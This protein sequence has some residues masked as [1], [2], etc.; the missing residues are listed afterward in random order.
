GGALAG[1]V[2]DHLASQ[3]ALAYDR[4]H[5]L[6]Y[7][8]NAGSN[9]L[10][11]FLVHGD[12]LV[13]RQVISSGGSFPVSVTTHGGLVYVLNARD[14]GSIQ[15]YLRVGTN[16]LRIPSWHRSLGLD[17]TAAPEF[18]HTPGQ[19]A[20]TPDGSRLIVTT[21]GNGSSIDVFGVNAL[22]G[23][24]ATPVVTADPAAVPFAVTFDA[25][26][27]VAVSEAGV[28]NAVAT[29]TLNA[30][31]TLSLVARTATG[32]A[33]T[34]WI[35]R[36]GANLYASNAGNASLSGFRDDGSGALTALGNT[37]TGAGT[38]DA[39]ASS[40]GEN[41]YVQTGASGGVDEFHVNA[42]G[43][44]TAIGSVVVPGAVGGEGI[45]AG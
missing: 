3:G 16:L 15:G 27:H 18:T 19:V 40:D 31:R 11:V 21:K 43:S 8:V 42:D 34:C 29:F 33:A 38:V 5:G 26:G 20:F 4:A 37:T 36:S 41:V 22:G 1:S 10:T 2:V 7:A 32:Q 35:V 23:P 30:D 45:V 14:G 28:P 24:S 44:L 17:P 25:G 9:T 12:H 6:L 13:R 39:A